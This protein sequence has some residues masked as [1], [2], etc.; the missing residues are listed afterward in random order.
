MAID[1]SRSKLKH[2]W[3]IYILVAIP[4]VLVLTFNYFPIFNGFVHIFYRWDGDMVE[5]FIGFQNIVKLAHDSDLW[6]S[7]IV[8]GIFIVSNLLKMIIPIMAALVPASCH[9]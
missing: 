6:K 1:I 3:P 5:E 2:Y 8:V 4:L 9:Q 7:F